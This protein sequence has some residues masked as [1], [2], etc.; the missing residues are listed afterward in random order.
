VAENLLLCQQLAVLT[1]P[2]RRRPRARLRLWDTLVWI[3]ARLF[4]AG[5][6]EHLR[7][8][9]PDT[10]VRWHRQGWRW[11]PLL[12]LEVPLSRRTSASEPRGTGVGEPTL[13]DSTLAVLGGVGCRFHES[14]EQSYRR[15]SRSRSGRQW[16]PI[17]AGPQVP[18]HGRQRIDEGGLGLGVPGRSPS[19]EILRIQ[20]VREQHNDTEQTEQAGGRTPDGARTPLALGLQAEVRSFK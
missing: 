9:T 20:G 7:S 10:V 6:R 1:R 8:V 17:P 11:A 5:W 18:A 16:W 4:C 3:L 14:I 15:I 19:G 2:T 13:F 12:A